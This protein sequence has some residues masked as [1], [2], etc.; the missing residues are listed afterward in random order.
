MNDYTKADWN[1]L[2]AALVNSPDEMVEHLADVSP[3]GDYTLEDWQSLWAKRDTSFKLPDDNI[4][5]NNKAFRAIIAAFVDAELQRR[6]TLAT[7]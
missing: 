4:I 5:R 2:V 7:E 3:V 6:K 1:G